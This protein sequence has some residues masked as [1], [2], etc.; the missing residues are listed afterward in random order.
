MI[1]ESG[2]R[3]LAHRFSATARFE[4][5]DIA[6][7]HGLVEANQEAEGLREKLIARIRAV[8]LETSYAVAAVK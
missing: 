1:A 5:S 6:K 8:M 2:A 7:I 3:E 4:N